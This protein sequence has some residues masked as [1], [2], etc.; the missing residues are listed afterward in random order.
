[1]ERCT[2]IYAEDRINANATIT[3]KALKD[4][5]YGAGA[6]SALR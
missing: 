1:M 6:E 2:R 5:I 3:Q 4:S